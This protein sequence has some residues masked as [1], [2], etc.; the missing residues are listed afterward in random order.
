M[1]S[2]LTPTEKSVVTGAYGDLFDTFYRDIIVYK[3]PLETIVS[4]LSA[5][6][7]FGYGDSQQQDAVTYTEVKQTFP[8]LIKY[9]KAEMELIENQEVHAMFPQGM[10]KIKVKWDCKDYISN[11]ALYGKTIK[12]I[13]DGITF[14]LSSEQRQGGLLGTGFYV[15]YLLRTK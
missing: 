12:I 10:V 9:P 1:P 14:I 15:F 4:P 8:A 2:L 5:S 11:H 6:F 3:S 7:G 13:V